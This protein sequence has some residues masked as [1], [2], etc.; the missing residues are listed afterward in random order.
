VEA[1][2]KAYKMPEEVNDSQLA[3]TIEASLEATSK[4][5]CS[6]ITRNTQRLNLN[7]RGLIA[8]LSGKEIFGILQL[9]RRVLQLARS[10]V[11]DIVELVV[12][13][14]AAETQESDRL[15]KM[16]LR[17]ADI[18]ENVEAI[19]E[20][21]EEIIQVYHLMI[22]DFKSPAKEQEVFRDLI[23]ASSQRLIVIRNRIQKE[24]KAW[25]RETRLIWRIPTEV[26][27]P[28]FLFALQGELDDYLNNDTTKPF[29]STT[30]SL[31]HVCSDWRL[32]V[33]NAPQLPALV[34][35]PPVRSWFPN[36]YDRLSEAIQRTTS[37]ITVL[38]NLAQLF[39]WGYYAVNR[40]S[41]PGRPGTLK[42]MSRMDIFGDREFTLHIYR[43]TK[44]Y[45]DRLGAIPFRKAT[46]M[47]I[48]M[49]VHPRL[50]GPF[51]D[52]LSGFESLKS[53]TITSYHPDATW[54]MDFTLNIRNYLPRLRVLR[55]LL[56]ELPDRMELPQALSS[57]LEEFHLYHEMERPR[58]GHLGYIIALP[59][60]QTLGTLFSDL[61][62]YQAV[63]FGT[64][65]SLVL[66][67]SSFH[68][69]FNINDIENLDNIFHQLSKLC[70]E[71]WK[72]H[73]SPDHLY[74]IVT[75]LEIFARKCPTLK[76]IK[77]SDSFVDGA[78]F[79]ELFKEA[80]KGD[81]LGNL[82]VLTLSFTSG[83]TRSQCDE[84]LLLVSKWNVH[85]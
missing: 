31:S 28:I 70:F 11:H 38:T 35:G 76:F 79:V 14:K 13:N 71:S 69:H 68:R 64:L 6:A 1:K 46:T 59:N 10:M 33:Q 82:E 23:Q 50:T 12:E 3:L 56:K 73:D 37:S 63:N 74:G 26:W 65:D 34:Y 80:R 58:P 8:I 30:I 2:L 55:F 9:D 53:L 57:L 54:A 15:E 39:P 83:I 45:D 43:P 67:S 16:R 81:S 62:I 29:R 21:Q 17:L 75:V 48:T 20:E 85:V 41:G 61:W 51:F 32:I 42:A 27:E 40:P 77:I 36:E 24:K 7:Y 49:G 84:L 60:L 47:I 4:E 25:R 22:A 19:T 44:G 52:M 18:I 72:D 78:A 5:L 66:Y